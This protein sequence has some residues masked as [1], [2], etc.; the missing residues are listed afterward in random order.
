MKL[1][2]RGKNPTSSKG[3]STFQAQSM[4][5]ASPEYIAVTPSDSKTYKTKDLIKMTVVEFT[6]QIK[7]E[8]SP[9]KEF[10]AGSDIL[11]RNKDGRSEGKF[12]YTHQTETSSGTTVTK[13]SGGSIAATVGM[14][15]TTKYFGLAENKFSASIETSGNW[16]KGTETYTSDTTTHTYAFEFPVPAKCDATIAI[17]KKELPTRIDWKATFYVSGWI[18]VEVAVCIMNVSIISFYDPK[19]SIGADAYLRF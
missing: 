7:K 14:E 6:E 5:I 11:Y 13:S 4:E 2:V 19:W 1:V 10:L 15:F 12:T 3:A 9:S 17:M 18:D 16:Q 8:M